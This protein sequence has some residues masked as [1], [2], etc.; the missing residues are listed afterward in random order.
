VA[1]PWPRRPRNPGSIPGSG[2]SFVSYSKCPDRLWGPF[3]TVG[4]GIRGNEIAD[5]S[6]ETVLFKGL[7]DQNFSCGG[8]RQNIRRNIKTVDG[9]PAFGVLAFSL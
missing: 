6:Q 3:G 8:S 2:K 9:K 5:S 7:M 1:R 4:A